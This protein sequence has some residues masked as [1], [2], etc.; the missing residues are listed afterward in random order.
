MKAFISHSSNDKVFAL[1]LA[2]DLRMRAGIDAWL[3]QWEVNPGDKIPE[4]LEAG[5]SEAGIFVLILSPDSVNSPWVDWER[6]SWLM[7][8]IEEEKLAKEESRTPERRLIP[9]LY[10][11]CKKPAFLQPIHHIKITDH[12]YENGFKLLADT[13]LGVSKKPPLKQEIKP[14]VTPE[15]GVPRRIYTLALLKSLLPGQFDEVVFI[16]NMPSAHLPTN[17][18][19][20][21]KAISLINYAEQ[22]EGEDVSELL[23]TIFKVAPHLTRGC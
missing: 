6:Q 17:V 13:I 10:R 3:D 12:D 20:V 5:I 4:R 15:T 8:Q 9:V 11:D 7:I 18:A 16:Y 14:P 1:R 19:Q 21:Q 22:R 23:N 2:T